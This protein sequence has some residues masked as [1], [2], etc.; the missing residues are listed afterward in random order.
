MLNNKQK[1]M[2]YMHETIENYAGS[3]VTISCDG[4]EAICA[5]ETSECTTALLSLCNEVGD[6]ASMYLNMDEVVKLRDHLNTMLPKHA[7]KK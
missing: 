6:I 7:R 5:H 1:G 2:F 4:P 3:T